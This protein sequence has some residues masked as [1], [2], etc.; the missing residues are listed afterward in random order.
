[1]TVSNGTLPYSKCG[2]TSDSPRTEPG[3]YADGRFGIRI[4]DIV[5]VQK[6]APPNNFGNVGFLKFE[7]VT[8]V[9]SS[10]PRHG[11]SVFTVRCAVPEAPQAHRSLAAEPS[12]AEMGRRLPRGGARQGRAFAARRGGLGSTGLVEEGDTAS[13]NRVYQSSRRKQEGISPWRSSISWCANPPPPYM[14]TLSVH[15]LKSPVQEN[16]RFG[17]SSILC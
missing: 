3:Y 10:S 15:L 2:Q 17:Q 16:T 8:M 7:H 12:G 4:E 13:V 9:R 1:M 11:R 14:H 6:A 5:I